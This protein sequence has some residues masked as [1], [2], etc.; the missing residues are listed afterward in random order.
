METKML[1]KLKG[2]AEQRCCRATVL[3]T[4][5]CIHSHELVIAALTILNQSR[6]ILSLQGICYHHEC[7]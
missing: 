4:A 2:T 7:L 5:R 6:V 1:S 3:S